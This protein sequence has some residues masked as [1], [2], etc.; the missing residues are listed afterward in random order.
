MAVQQ[1]ATLPERHG[2][3]RGPGWLPQRSL[4]AQPVLL[5][6]YLTAVLAYYLAL[7]GWELARTPLFS[8]E[9]LLFAALLACGGACVEAARRLGLP[10]G[11][12]HD[13][14]SAWWLPIALLLP[15]LY[16]LI[17]PIPLCLLQQLRVRGAVF[18]GRAFSAA[19]LGLAGAAAS[20]MSGH[21][22][23]SAGQVR[24]PA[25]WLSH[26]GG[27][28]WFTRPLT[29][30]SA[31]GCA[32][33]FSVL[34]AALVACAVRTAGAPPRPRRGA[35]DSESLIINVTGV[36][37]GL[38]ITIACLLSSVLLFVAL[39]PVILLQ[40]SLLHQQLRAAARTDAKTGLLNAA[41]WHREADIEISRVI[42]AGDS[43]ALL[44]I[45]ID[46]FK[47][48]ND[49]YGHLAGDQVLAGL[50]DVLRRAVRDAD[51]V[52]R[53]GGEEFVV[54]LPGADAAEAGQVAERLR[55]QVSAEVTV[56]A[57]SG[58]GVTVSIGAAVIGLHGEDLSGLLSSA[59]LAMYRAKEA[60]RNR[61]C[62]SG[63][64]GA[65]IPASRR[66]LADPQSR[67]GSGGRHRAAGRA[68]RAG[69]EPAGDR[70]TYRR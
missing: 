20:T 16:A 12:S 46:H 39:P 27:H 18:Y 50:A 2:E 41:A 70:V 4:L 64:D 35:R 58:V 31:I 47:Q 29:V 63:P 62:L 68:R 3:S 59:D 15:P 24:D 44:L 26:P 1:A 54:L 32:A 17:A 14:L 40:R 48:V 67:S 25:A 19:A 33:L 10:A 60:G 7:T 11:I 43:L 38:L 30:V 55:E 49:T 28:V 21:F 42:R 51:V 65:R 45:D 9:L 6:A 36:C 61:V 69:V 8:G 5:V 53:F 57:A 37:V 22:G 66:V 56:P 52:G 34:N 13:L 23:L